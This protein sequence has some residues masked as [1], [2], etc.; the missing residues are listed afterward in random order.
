MKS[1]KAVIPIL[2]VAFGLSSLVFDLESA[3]AESAFS[4]NFEDGVADGWTQQTGSWRVVNGE[5]FVSVGIVENGITTVDGLD[6]KDCTIETKFRFADDVGFRAGLVFRYMG[7]DT[8]YAY[9]ERYV[10]C[11]RSE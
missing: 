10:L 6:L 8:Y 3:R 1:C 11:F 9:G 7:K 4:D 2:L 5:Y